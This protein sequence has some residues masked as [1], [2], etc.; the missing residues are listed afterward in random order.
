MTSGR[1]TTTRK[2]LVSVT[3]LDSD[4]NRQLIRV[5][6]DTGFTGYLVLPERYMRRLG[7]TARRYS[8]GRP[9]TGEVI[10]IPTGRATVIWQGQSRAVEVLQLDSEPLLGMEFLWNHRI[11]IDAVANG[12]VTVAPLQSESAPE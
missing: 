12:A 5:V 9:A 6:L 10:R 2:P 7:L 3:I 11:T 8:Q 4:G 1:V